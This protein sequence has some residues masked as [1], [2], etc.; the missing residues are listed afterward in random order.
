MTKPPRTPMSLSPSAQ[1]QFSM[2]FDSTVLHG[3]S[4]AERRKAVMHLAQLLMLAAG[5]DVEEHDDER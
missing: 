3:L 2:V 1:R 4:A 5:V